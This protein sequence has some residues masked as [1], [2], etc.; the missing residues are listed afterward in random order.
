MSATAQEYHDAEGTRSLQPPVVPPTFVLG[1]HRSGTSALAGALHALGMSFGRE[2]IEPLAGVNERGFFEDARVLALHSELLEHLGRSWRH[3]L[4]LPVGW[5]CSEGLAPFLDRADA[6]LEEFIAGGCWGMKDPRLC[7]LFPFWHRQLAERELTPR[8]VITLRHPAEIAASLGQRDQL[9][10]GLSQHLWMLHYLHAEYHSR[11]LERRVVRYETLLSQPAG[12]LTELSNWLGLAATE[13]EYENASSFVSASLAHHQDL[14]LPDD[15]LIRQLWE[16]FDAGSLE[17][18]ETQQTLDGQR[19]EVH[20]ALKALEPLVVAQTEQ[21][22]RWETDFAQAADQLDASRSALVGFEHALEQLKVSGQ[23]L[24]GFE[25]AVMRL[26]ELNAESLTLQEQVA[27]LKAERLSFLNRDAAQKLHDRGEET[28]VAAAR[29]DRY[30][31]GHIDLRVENNS[32]TCAIRYINESGIP[33]RGPVLEVGCAGGHVGKV[34]REHGYRVWGVETNAGAVVGAAKQLDHVYHG[35]IE[36]FLADPAFEN[37][38]FQFLIFG[39]VLE[40]LLD[41]A[42]VLERCKR[43]LVPNGALVVSVPNVAHRAVR[44][45][46]LEGRW[47]YDTAGIM[48]STHLHFYTRDSLVDLFTA[49]GYVVDRLSA[50]RL[51]AEDVGIRFKPAL[52]ALFDEHMHDAEQDVFQFVAL[53]RDSAA[54][55]LAWLNGRF[56]VR[57]PKRILC[58]PPLESS[59]LYPIRLGDP[60]TRFTELFGGELRSRELSRVRDED[61]EWADTIVLQRESND[62]VVNFLRRAKAAGKR[63]IFDID[64]LLTEVP[65]YLS[66]AQHARRVKPWLEKALREAD[67]LSVS[68]P[69]LREALLPYNPATFITPNY[70]YTGE[71]PI[72]H[73]ESDEPVR[74]VIASSDT[75]RV[76]FL[77][78]SLRTICADPT[79]KVELVG[80]G[81]PGE[82]LLDQGLPIQVVPIMPHGQFKAFIAER[83]NAIALIPLDDNRFNSCKSAIKFF[84]YALAGVPCACSAVIT[85]AA[86]ISDP[87]NGILCLDNEAHWTDA[88]RVLVTSPGRRSVTADRARARCLKDHNLN[89]TAAA[90]SDI[91]QHTDALAT[92]PPETWPRRRLRS[93]PRLLLGTCRHLLKPASYRSAW[94]LLQQKGLAGLRD[95]WRT[96]F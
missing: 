61:V 73:Y 8:V 29:Q 46:L 49:T 15:P 40:H 95:K 59:S 39:D 1:M 65:D 87:D 48:D 11:G 42:K 44:L 79:L 91:I 32:H 50:I 80:I 82:F 4:P 70:A 90:W 24:A 45:M 67:A 55:D 37:K 69:E 94:R 64:D 74:I 21:V 25:D 13:S 14:L 52:E 92:N 5:E 77:V 16:H 54:P 31:H 68:T 6:L 88:I 38:R 27:L 12:T 62:F 85:Y 58:V 51:S 60:L 78:N 43:L 30:Y 84:D 76:D 17:S 75:V 36:D 10:A 19:L 72:R 83:D 26:K 89:L 22:A 81:P 28:V 57:S 9:P 41:P 2:L 71:A 35:T 66:V 23:A 18:T 93:R 7:L 20:K 33:E 56:Q 47:E 63:V 34:L 53:V 3:P 86:V 96:M